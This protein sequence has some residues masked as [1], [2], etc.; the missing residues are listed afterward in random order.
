MYDNQL[1][2]KLIWIKIVSNNT[3]ALQTSATVLCILLVLEWNQH[4]DTEY[5]GPHGHGIGVRMCVLSRC[6]TLWRS[7]T[8]KNENDLRLFWFEGSKKGFS[9]KKNK[10][11]KDSLISHNEIYLLT[12]YWHKNKQIH[13]NGFWRCL[14]GT[15]SIPTVDVPTTGGTGGPTGVTVILG[16]FNDFGLLDRLDILIL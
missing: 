10:R 16:N 12:A 5:R 4:H 11:R 3:A 8:A 6:C 15:P 2:I 13:K 14:G 1:T 9:K 7:F